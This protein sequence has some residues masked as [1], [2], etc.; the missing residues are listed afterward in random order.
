[1]ELYGI[2]KDSIERQVIEI[3]KEKFFV[4]IFLFKVFNFKCLDES[5]QLEVVVEIKVERDYRGVKG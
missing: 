5:F 1:M 2:L 4:C 3:K